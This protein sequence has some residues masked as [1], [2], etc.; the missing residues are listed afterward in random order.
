M[1]GLLPVRETVSW[2]LTLAMKPFGRSQFDSVR[3]VAAM[4]EKEAAMPCAEAWGAGL[5]LRARQRLVARGRDDGAF[6]SLFLSLATSVAVAP[7]CFLPSF[8]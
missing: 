5:D 6:V 1:S 3:V 2:L 8:S 7:C 4:S